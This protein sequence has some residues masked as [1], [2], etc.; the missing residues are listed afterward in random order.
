MET[1]VMKGGYKISLLII[2]CMNIL[3]GN[4]LHAATD[5]DMMVSNTSYHLSGIWGRSGQEVYA[6]GES[7]TI[8]FYNGI[9]WKRMSSNSTAWLN[10]IWGGSNRIIA[11]GNN[12]TLLCYENGSWSSMVS[13]TNQD[14]YAIWGRSDNEIYAVGKNGLILKYTN[15]QWSNMNSMTLIR[16][17]DVWGTS[18]NIYAIGSNGKVMRY[19]GTAWKQEETNTFNNLNGIWG[20]SDTDLWVA[21]SNGTMLRFENTLWSETIIHSFINLNCIMGFS[22]INIFSGGYQGKIFHFDGNYNLTWEPMTTPSTSSIN[23]IWGSSPNDI[24]AVGDDGVILHHQRKITLTIPANAVEGNAVLNGTVS[25]RYIHDTDLHI[26]LKNSNPLEIITPDKVTIPQG[27]TT[28]IFPITVID[29]QRIDDAQTVQLTAWTPDF[30]TAQAM[31]IIADN[32]KKLI[33][34][35]VPQ[36]AIENDGVITQGGTVSISGILT[37]DL[38]ITLS[39]NAPQNVSV[40]DTLKI[41]IGQSQATFDIAIIDNTTLNGLN[42]VSITASA[43]GWSSDNKQIQ[44]VDNEEMVL[45]LSLPDQVIEGSGRLANAG[46]VS[47]SCLFLADTT[48]N[49]VS[50]L[51]DKVSVPE[52]IVIPNGQQWTKFDLTILDN[53]LIDGLKSVNIQAHATNWISDQDV[54]KVEDNE[55]RNLKLTI[56]KFV[57]EDNTVLKNAGTINISGTFSSDLMLQLSSSHPQDLEVPKTIII[58]MGHQSVSFDLIVRDDELIEETQGITLSVIAA[59][60]QPATETLYMRDNEGKVLN[61]WV[62]PRPNE[63]DGLLPHAGSIFLPGIYTKNLVVSLTSD[64]PNLVQVPQ[65]ITIPAGNQTATFSLT[66]IDNK[67]IGTRQTVTIFASVT[68]WETGSQRLEVVDDE[69]KEISL[70]LP[71]NVKENDHILFKSGIVSIPGT[72]VKD[73]LIQLFAAP[74]GK[75]EIPD[76][77]MIPIGYTSTYFDIRINDNSLI[78]GTETITVDAR[79]AL[80]T[81]WTAGR[82]TIQIEDNEHRMIFLSMPDKVTEGSGKLVKQASIN[83]PGAY[84]SHLI[85][86]L[87]SNNTTKLIVPE[88]VT[89]PMGYTSMTFD[90]TLLDNHLIDGDS[91]VQVIAEAV[92]WQG[93]TKVIQVIDNE[94]RTLTL[95]MPDILTEQDRVIYHQAYIHLQGAFHNDLTVQLKVNPLNQLS[96][97]SNVIIPAGKT[98]ISFPLTIKNNATI[99]GP[100]QITI[101]AQSGPGWTAASK[102]ITLLDDEEKALYLT[103]P[104]S[105]S[106]NS[107]LLS[108]VGYI[109]LNG[110]SDTQ[111]LIHLQTDPSNKITLPETV[112]LAKGLT[113]VFFDVQSPDNQDIEG[114]LSILITASCE[115]WI[116][117]S[118]VVQY[119]GNE[120]MTLNLS[121]VPSVKEGDNVVINGGTVSVN[122]VLGSDLTVQL[123][124]DTISEINVPVRVV[125]P[126]GKQMVQFNLSVIDDYLFDGQKQAT[127]IAF[128]EGWESSSVSVIIEDN[129]Q[130]KLTFTLPQT[131]Q[132]ELNELTVIGK[133]RIS[134]ITTTDIL[135]N[136]SSSHMNLLSVPNTITLSAGTTLT[137]F[138][139]NLLNS[140]SVGLVPVTIQ[141]TAT[142][143]NDISQTTYVIGGQYRFYGDFNFDGEVQLN[144]AILG[145]QQI[146]DIP[147]QTQFY[148]S[149]DTNDDQHIGLEDVIYILLNISME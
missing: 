52:T 89:M 71:E 107:G 34:L 81:E 13:N 105:I 65:T 91:N 137:A 147:S 47:F 144:D 32:E 17:N 69:N 111:L 98:M 120:P 142:G 74:S 99:E 50:L 97:P 48:V 28:K 83:I 77:L 124:S 40:P 139:L 42:N 109:S 79:V 112:V 131:I 72:Y 84:S 21:G 87:T 39:S 135:V 24:F 4:D 66:L 143:F 115:D 57:N 119:I 100:R 46:M 33:S 45:H 148:L 108:K 123:L 14:I 92:N 27:A 117:G 116:S 76:T 106:E 122:G 5:W 90:I 132:T 70:K 9:Q 114:T 7:G 126:K 64:Q 133:I 75:I 38:N 35:T 149:G 20:R 1:I 80:F 136:L 68:G 93:D 59:G 26:Y 19:D 6:V 94:K 54:I 10:D 103:M 140:Q 130:S 58:P 101:T 110:I 23:A 53:T 44:V 51:P 62:T 49:L 25:I 95:T 125:I 11:V 55:N 61:V 8:L 85:V 145:L 113:Q 2:L 138:D 134:G 12:G 36:R 43:T 56:P 104:K 30:Y 146:V 129:E 22:K 63:K 121:V 102:K 82:D 41:P 15:G 60:W 3:V 78:N 31:M 88:T 16:F 86:N 127:L 67:A 96:I 141:A 118:S 18:Q 29:D 73:V 128:A 37:R